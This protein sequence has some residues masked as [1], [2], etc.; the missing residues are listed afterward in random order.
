VIEDLEKSNSTSFGGE[1]NEAK[2]K[3]YRKGGA[4]K[5]NIMGYLE[6][7]QDEHVSEGG[8]NRMGVLEKKVASGDAEQ[9]R[10]KRKK[11]EVHVFA[12]LLPYSKKGGQEYRKDEEE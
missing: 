11:P 5:N 7:R 6:R 10:G 12:A 2:K 4:G 8:L 1:L 9:K 3:T